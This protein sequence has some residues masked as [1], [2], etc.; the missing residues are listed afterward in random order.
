M[1]VTMISYLA[2]LLIHY[3]ISFITIHFLVDL[4]SL[5]SPESGIQSRYGWINVLNIHQMSPLVNQT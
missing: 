4:I 1:F 3:A 2:Y 5:H